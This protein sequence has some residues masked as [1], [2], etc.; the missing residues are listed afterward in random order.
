MD[1]RTDQSNL[2]GTRAR[3][4][5]RAPDAPA[6][7]AWYD[8][9]RRSLPWRAA[10][11][12][13]PDP[14][15]VWLS[16]IMLQ[17]TRVETVAPYFMKFVTR[18]PDVQ[19]L[20]AAKLSEVLSAWAGLGYY[21]RARNLHACAREIAGRG[22]EF[23]RSEAELREL[24][25]IGAYTA[26][27]VAAIAFEARAIAIDGNVERV[28]ARL[29]ALREPLPKAKAKLRAL[30][31]QLQPEGRHG[32]FAQALMELGAI[33]CTPR[34]PDCPRCP[35]QGA[36]EANALGEPQR[37]P[38]KTAK[39]EGKLRRGAAFVVLREDGA[40]LLRTRPANG[41][42][43]GMT[44][45]PTSEWTHRFDEKRTVEYAPKFNSPLPGGERSAL[46]KSDLS[47]FGPLKCRTR[48]H[49]SS[50][51]SRVRGKSRRASFRNVPP[52]PNP[53][54]NGEREKSGWQRL[55]GTVRHVFTHF[56]LE[57]VVLTA[58]VNKKT[59][60]PKGM[61]FVRETDL[62]RE[63]LPTLMRKVLAH[64]SRTIQPKGRAT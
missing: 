61:R 9:N 14:Y 53:L 5:A 2:A 48:E 56:P 1:A 59:R 33:I 57:L 58:R 52:H 26:A 8:K 21:A 13:K 41:L 25:G 23:P 38:R 35:W 30:A 63:A 50:D 42:L 45:V 11:G 29:F 60:P 55:P 15:C 22:G 49:P 24:H 64:A 43:G 31:E 54:P 7:L 28:V 46:P 32:D 62:D 51:A 4:K 10:P 12:V 37:F 19:A 27:A 20:A 39:K 3:A 18:W 6:L 34:K 16:E 36:C 40:L 17:Q 44:E 47:D